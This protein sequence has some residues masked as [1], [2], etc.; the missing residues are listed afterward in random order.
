MEDGESRPTSQAGLMGTYNGQRPCV[1]IL[2][3][4]IKPSAGCERRDKTQEPR[5]KAT[6]FLRFGAKPQVG[7]PRWGGVGGK[8][9]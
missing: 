1:L 2:P 8:A 7:L 3:S 4:K 6:G 9:P 5:Y